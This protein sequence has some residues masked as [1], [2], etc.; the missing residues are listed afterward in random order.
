MSVFC[1]NLNQQIYR[2]IY[3]ANKDGIQGSSIHKQLNIS[4]KLVYK[5]LQSFSRLYNVKRVSDTHNKSMVYRY[6]TDEFC[7]DNLKQ[8]IGETVAQ[9]N[10]LKFSIHVG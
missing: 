5:R 4:H 6:F 3:A 1:E 9:N 7:D 10:T 2:M 8:N